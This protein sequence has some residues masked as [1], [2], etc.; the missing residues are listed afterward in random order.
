M[1][2]YPQPKGLPSNGTKR[3]AVALDQFVVDGSCCNR[4]LTFSNANLIEAFDN[5]TDRV[6]STYRSSLVLVGY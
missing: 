3:L 4:S 1:V 6:K 5:I 2:V